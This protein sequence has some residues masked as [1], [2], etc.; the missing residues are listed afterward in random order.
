MTDTQL[1]QDL[2]RKFD[3][4]YWTG[5]K[6]FKY[7]NHTGANLVWEVN[8]LDPDLVIDAG[9]GFNRYKGHIKNLIGFDQEPFPYADLICKIEDAP[10]RPESADVVM[11]LGSVQFGDITLVEHQMNKIVSWVKPGGYIIMRTMDKWLRDHEYA[12]ADRHYIWTEDDIKR[13]GEMHN[14]TVVKGIFTEEIKNRRGDIVQST[15]LAW[16]WQKP[17]K[18]KRYKIGLDTCRID[19]R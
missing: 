11:A 15:R 18:L 10:F 16:W 4:T 12:Y 17:G 6:S 8:S 14:L 13:I 9:C 19:E 3:P 5:Y 1:D 2:K 7:Y